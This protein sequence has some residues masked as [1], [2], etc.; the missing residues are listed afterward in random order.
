MLAFV[1]AL[2]LLLTPTPVPDSSARWESRGV[3]PGPLRRCYVFYYDAHI[4]T[5]TVMWLHPG[6]YPPPT[7]LQV[8]EWVWTSSEVWEGWHTYEIPAPATNFSCLQ[9]GIFD[10]HRSQ[11]LVQFEIYQANSEWWEWDGKAWTQVFDVPPSLTVHW[12]TSLTPDLSLVYDSH[13]RVIYVF[14]FTDREVWEYDGT[15]WAL[16]GEIPEGAGSLGVI[17]PFWAVYDPT[18][19]VV[20]VPN[21]WSWDGQTWQRH[22]T[23]KLDVSGIVGMYERT[24]NIV[25][26]SVIPDEGQY[27]DQRKTWEWNGQIW[28]IVDDQRWTSRCWQGQMVFDTVRET[29]FML[30]GHYEWPHQM[31]EYGHDIPPTPTP[32]P[33][34]TATPT[35]TA[36]STTKW[37]YLPLAVK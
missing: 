33:M 18:R 25:L 19:R 32:S 26:K 13:R 1:M 36:T 35:A 29:L 8:S 10:P 3:A 23:N 22:N 28:Y 34:P 2:M 31:W 17:N 21:M 30:A 27:C 24:G 9:R 16:V 20:W 4:H 5:P 15:A 12:P 6:Y 7:T 37:L 11:L 14:N